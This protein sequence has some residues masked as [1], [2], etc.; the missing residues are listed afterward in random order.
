VSENS[1]KKYLPGIVATVAILV[2]VALA[3]VGLKSL[4]PDPPG[5]ET[6]TT[7]VQPAPATITLI[8]PV[9]IDCRAYIRAEIPVKGESKTVGHYILFSKTWNTDTLDLHAVGDVDVCVPPDASI[10]ESSQDGSEVSVEIDAT[11]VVFNRPRVDNLA[12]GIKVSYDE[13]AGK[14]F[15]RILPLASLFIDTNADD[16]TVQA[17]GFAQ[18]V[19]GSSECMAVAWPAVKDAISLAYES[20]AQAKPLPDGSLPKVSVEFVGTPN[21]AQYAEVIDTTP[22]GDDVTFRVD[23]D[24]I[25]CTVVD[26][27]LQP[28]EE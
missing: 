6:I 2:V 16:M 21:Y 11:R 24:G 17:E 3:F 9:V 23:S 27:A 25:Q 13:G 28:A 18:S 4:F 8:K 20:Q 22:F 19:I 7:F 10:I 5:T 12:T 1:K 26:S 15:L 14:T